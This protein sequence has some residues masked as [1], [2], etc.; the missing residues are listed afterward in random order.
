MRNVLIFIFALL[1]AAPVVAQDEPVEPVVPIDPVTVEP[2]PDLEP[3]QV[4]EPEPVVE[5]EPEPTPE[6][7]PVAEPEAQVEVDNPPDFEETLPE[8]VVPGVDQ[9]SIRERVGAVH[10]ELMT[11]VANY[12]SGEV[13]EANA[14]ARV[15]TARAELDAAVA[16]HTGVLDSRSNAAGDLIEVLVGIIQSAGALVD[17]VRAELVR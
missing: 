10:A 6:P 1:V 3:V 7:D 14:E 13:Q 9:P 12:E 2:V 4:P 15:A 17:E 11:A 16:E 8:V 5:P